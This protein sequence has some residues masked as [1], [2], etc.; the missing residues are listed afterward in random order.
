MTRVKDLAGKNLVVPLLVGL[1]LVLAA[2]WEEESTAQ[3]EALPLVI[4]VFALCGEGAP[5]GGPLARYATRIEITMVGGEM[6]EESGEIIVAP[7]I[8]AGEVNR[9]ETIV[10]QCQDIL[11][12]QESF[13]GFVTVQVFPGDAFSVSVSYEAGGSG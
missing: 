13:F 2:A 6:G 1:L 12:D 5:P 11:Q 9:G 8:L 3:Q 10:V 7:D 4:P